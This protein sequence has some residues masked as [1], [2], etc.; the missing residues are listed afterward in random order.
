MSSIPDQDTR[1]DL[2]SLKKTLDCSVKTLGHECNS[3]QLERGGLGEVEQEGQGGVVTKH[4]PDEVH[5]GS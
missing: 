5:V 2:K 1:R 4:C 3:T